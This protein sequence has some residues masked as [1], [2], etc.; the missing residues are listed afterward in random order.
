MHVLFHFAIC[1]TDLLAAPKA[2][3]S[4]SIKQQLKQAA[5]VKFDPCID[6]TQSLE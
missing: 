4:F 6:E 1:I 3:Y 2:F 5:K